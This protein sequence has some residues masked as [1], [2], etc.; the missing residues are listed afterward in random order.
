LSWTTGAAKVGQSLLFRDL[1]AVGSLQKTPVSRFPDTLG[2]LLG[3]EGM[4]IGLKL[5]AG[6]GLFESGHRHGVD[7]ALR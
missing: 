1:I 7:D 5:L 2:A 6:F 4:E 3:L